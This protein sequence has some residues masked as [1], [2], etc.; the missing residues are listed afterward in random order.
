MKNF[1]RCILPVLLFFIPFQGMTQQ[2]FLEGNQ[3]YE[4]EHYKTAAKLYESLLDSMT[5]SSNVYYNLGNAY[6]KSGFRGK[7]I[8]AYEMALKTDPKNEDAK[9]NL[10]FVNLQIGDPGEP[11]EAAVTEWLKRLLFSPRINLWSYI[12]ICCSIAL[13]LCIL[14]FVM[15]GPARRRN[16]SLMAGMTFALLLVFSLVT[17]Y[18]HKQSILEHQEAIVV[19]EQ[20]DVLLSPLQKSGVAFELEEGAKVHLLEVKETWLHIE[21]NGNPGWVKRENVWVI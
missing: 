10:E 5:Q 19:S 1:N 21:V 20:V 9:F 2:A 14:V 15:P 13:S 16:L 3:K 11:S 12:S 6:Y 7:A 18:F 17:A 8:W 4:E